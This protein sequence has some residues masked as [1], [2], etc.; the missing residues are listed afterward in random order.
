MARPIVQLT[1]K[2]S[3]DCADAYQVQSLLMDRRTRSRGDSQRP[4]NGIYEPG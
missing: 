2:M 4:E 1:K 3:L